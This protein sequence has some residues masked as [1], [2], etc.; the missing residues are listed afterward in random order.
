MTVGQAVEHYLSQ[1]KT[2]G[3][4]GSERARKAG[5]LK[6]WFCFALSLNHP[7]VSQSLKGLDLST[8][9]PVENSIKETAEEFLEVFRKESGSLTYLNLRTYLEAH[10][11]LVDPQ[12]SNLK[13]FLCL[14]GH[15]LSM[16]SLSE[17]LCRHVLAYLKNLSVERAEGYSRT[18]LIFCYEQGWLS[19][20]PHS[21]Q[22]AASDRVFENDFLGPPGGFWR[23]SLR[24]YL[25]FL[26]DQRNLSDGGIDYYVRKLKIFVNWLER[27]R[28]R[29]VQLDTLKT[30]ILYKRDQGITESTLSKY[31]YSVKYF[32]DFLITHDLIAQRDNPAEQLRVKGHEY[33]KRQALDETEVK[34]VIDHLEGEIYRTR[35]AEQISDVV[36]FFRAARD[37]CLFLVFVL[38]G[39]RLSEVSG[40]TL[41]DMDFEKRAFTIRAKGNRQTRKKIREVLVDDVVWAALRTYLK[42]RRHSG[43]R[44]LWISWNGTPLRASSINNLIHHRLK[45][46][47][48]LKPISPHSLRTTCASLYVK[49]GMDPYSLKTLLGHRSL[50]TTMDHYAQ[51][52]EE[53]LRELWQK[54]NPLAGFDDE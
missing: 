5:I 33:A 49:K 21:G 50:K 1:L 30:F 39:L 44:H 18:F 13:S 51:L 24:R 40:I 52:T 41:H 23:N 29:R 37:L 34:Q 27:S 28:C 43:Q 20:N 38:L 35:G 3:Y 46:A 53:Q 19:W 6:H 2:S 11:G 42:V 45:Q 16:Q 4:S 32:F 26:K 17:P 22:R 14:L 31:L 10:P 25:S 15:G 9:E 7:A 48:I 54:T 8:L 47:G 36:L 12:D